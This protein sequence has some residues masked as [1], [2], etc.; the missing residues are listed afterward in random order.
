MIRK[1]YRFFGVSVLVLFTCMITYAQRHQVAGTVT[2]ASGNPM[3]GVNILLK[4]TTTGSPTDA[5]G[6]FALEAEPGDV[7]VFSF[8]GYRSQEITV[9]NETNFNVA[10]PF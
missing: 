7:L 8:I 9:G 5:N 2:D 3:P 4:G 10:R 6:K 1:L